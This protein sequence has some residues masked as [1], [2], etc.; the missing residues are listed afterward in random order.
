MFAKRINKKTTYLAA[1]ILSLTAANSADAAGFQLREQGGSLQGLSF[2]G[3]TAKADDLSTIFFNPAGMTRLEGGNLQINGAYIAPS[4]KFSLT[5]AT[6]ATGGGSL[7][8]TNGDSTGDDAG[9]SAFVPSFYMLWD[10]PEDYK[11]GVSVNTP[12]GLSTSYESGWVGRYYAL[13]S[14]LKTV[15]VTPNIAKKVNDK[16]SLG[17]GIAIQYAE[18]TLTKAINF[19]AI[20]P[21]VTT[22]GKSNLTGDDIGFGM[23]LGALYEFDEDTRVGISYRSQIQNELEGTVQI[24]GALSGAA[25]ALTSG[26][27]QAELTTPDTLSVGVYHALDDKWAILSDFQWTNWSTFDELVVTNKDDGLLRDRVDEKWDSSYFLSVGTEY[28]PNEDT[29]WQF[30]IAYDTTPVEDQYRTFRIPDADRLWM[31]VGYLKDLDND[32]SIS[33]GYSHIF[34]DEVGV[35]EN[36]DPATAGIVS[37][38]FNA[39][40]N[41]LSA[42]F[43]KKF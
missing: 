32:T 30:G 16:L 31:S 2:A 13:D 38:N 41:I 26:A 12:F 15:T 14:E 39:N 24:T 10:L 27:A 18:A 11:L 34:A 36:A 35:T 8:P 5:N 40:V 42:N 33:V 29:T 43:T 37:G 4:T 7:Y 19:N 3:A 22:D 17:G 23:T 28:K 20:N 21:A 25:P 1:A 9:E 6:A